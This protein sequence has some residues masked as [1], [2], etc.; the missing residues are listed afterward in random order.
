[1]R[2]APAFPVSLSGVPT[3]NGLAVDAGQLI[4]T[5][6][7]LRPRRLEIRI[8]DVSLSRPVGGEPVAVL[9]SPFRGESV[10]FFV[11]QSCQP[12]R[13][14][15]ERRTDQGQTGRYVEFQYPVRDLRAAQQALVEAG[16]AGAAALPE[17]RST[18][19]AGLGH[20]RIRMAVALRLV[21]WI[22]LL[23]AAALA[24]GTIR[25][26]FPPDS[27]DT[28]PLATILMFSSLLGASWLSG[29]V[30]RSLVRVPRGQRGPRVV[31]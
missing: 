14:A 17:V 24:S 8:E 13:P 6:D 29:V 2:I 28:V 22:A 18:R 16:A 31:M 26:A 25:D 9:R 27:M 23:L 5:A 1:M 21:S 20:G 10:S 15:D 4:V 30:A 11:S 12:T 3:V 7:W 19:A